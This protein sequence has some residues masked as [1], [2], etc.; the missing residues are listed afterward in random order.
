MKWSARFHRYPGVS[1]TCRPLGT[2]GLELSLSII[3]DYGLAKRYPLC[4]RGFQGFAAMRA[5]NLHG[6]GW[7]EMSRWDQGCFR[8]VVEK[9]FLL[10]GWLESR[11][12]TRA[13]GWTA[14][15]SK[16]PGNSRSRVGFL[17]IKFRSRIVAS[18]K[19]TSTSSPLPQQNRIAASFMFMPPPQHAST[20]G[21]LPLCRTYLLMS[22]CISH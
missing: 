2:G 11:V 10:A 5:Q 20:I 13:R 9:A 19:P 14:W 12:E 4:P 7:R 16:L 6:H 18:W 1:L 21:P 22:L 3:R 15:T 8:I 17:S